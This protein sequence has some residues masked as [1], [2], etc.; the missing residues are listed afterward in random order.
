MD[1]SPQMKN[2]LTQLEQIKQQ[3]QL[4][5]AQMAQLESQRRE[6]E[7][8]LEGLAD[9]PE[10]AVVYKSAGSVLVK[11]DD[12]AELKGELDDEK[13]TLSVRLNTMEK[14]EAKLKERFTE[15]QTTLQKAL[16]GQ[17]NM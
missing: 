11:T 16:E 6:V 9:L 14:Q 10:D 17:Q 8:A 5:G 15:L 12:P 2:Q 7:L 3:L 1:L 13:E 4:L